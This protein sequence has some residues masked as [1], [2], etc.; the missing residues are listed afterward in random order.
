MEN[1]RGRT[2]RDMRA[3]CVPCPQTEGSLCLLTFRFCFL[4]STC[5]QV[6][7]RTGSQNVVADVERRTTWRTGRAQLKRPKRQDEP[8]LTQRCQR[9]KRR[10]RKKRLISLSLSGEEEEEIRGGYLL[11]QFELSRRRRLLQER[12]VCH[13]FEPNADGT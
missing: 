13:L 8:T 2:F 10:Q 7:E 5:T 11:F 6:T 4:R 12:D 3:I 1:K 9:S